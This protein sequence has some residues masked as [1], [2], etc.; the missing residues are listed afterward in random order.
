M[1]Q[2]GFEKLNVWQNARKLSKDVYL[3]TQ[4]FPPDEKFMLV[5]Q[6]RRA[7]ISVSSNIAE[8][9]SRSTKKD[10]GHFYTMAY[11][12]I[13][14]LLSQTIVAYDLEFIN[15]TQYSGIRAS[16][17]QVTNQLNALQKSI[18]KFPRTI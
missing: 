1:H 13:L 15:E 3:M 14:E 11:G 5:P 9:S 18:N 4:T 17:E 16:I 12:S 7:I 6:M 10:Q 2:Y 8:G